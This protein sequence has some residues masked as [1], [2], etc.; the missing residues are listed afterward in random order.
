MAFVFFKESCV[1]ISELVT[2]SIFLKL[3]NILSIKG[4]R[5]FPEKIEY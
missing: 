4:Q 2:E 5:K 3:M 1:C